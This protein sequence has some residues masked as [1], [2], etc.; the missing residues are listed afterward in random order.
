[1]SKPRVFLESFLPPH[2]RAEGG[3]EGEDDDVEEAG[4]DHEY[5]R[6]HPVRLM[7]RATFADS[8]A[9]RGVK[10]HVH[11]RQNILCDKDENTTVFKGGFS[12]R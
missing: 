7:A 5:E 9:L 4:H 12:E 11:S 10:H 3:L 6:V 8:C 2:F 1:M